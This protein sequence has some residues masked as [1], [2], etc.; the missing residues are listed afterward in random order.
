MVNGKVLLPRGQKI[1]NGPVL[2]SQYQ[3]LNGGYHFGLSMDD[4]TDKELPSV[5]V[6]S[7]NI[8][9]EEGKTY[10]LS[11]N[12]KNDHEINAFGTFLKSDPNSINLK[13]Y[14]TTQIYIGEIKISH[15]DT[16]KF[17]ISGTFWYNA[18]NSTGEIVKITDGRFDVHY[19]P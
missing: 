4:N 3:F 14:S 10:P 2:A 12:L 16:T 8:S 19:A 18:I 11:V 7:D 6:G 5:L 13:T 15:L 17:I 1:Q 9:F